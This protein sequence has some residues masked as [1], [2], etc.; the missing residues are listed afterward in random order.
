MGGMMTYPRLRMRNGFGK[1]PAE[2][3]GSPYNV[4]PETSRTF[5]PAYIAGEFNRM[6]QDYLGL[7]KD[8]YALRVV[9]A[10]AKE[11]G[12]SVP[13]VRR[14]L[15]AF[16]EVNSAGTTSPPGPPQRTD[17]RYTNAL[18]EQRAGK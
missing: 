11:A 10:I 3:D 18:K 13:A 5:S 14:V 12:V 7:S 6:E 4:P 16:F 8:P 17:N 2:V 1:R 15:S 9:K